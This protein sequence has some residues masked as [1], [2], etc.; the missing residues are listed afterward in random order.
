MNPTFMN[1]DADFNKEYY[2][3]GILPATMGCRTYVLSNCNG[4]PGVEG[5]GNNAPSTI[6]LP[7]I[8]ILANHN[9]DK[10]FEL[11]DKRID[12]TVEILM[13]RYE[14][15][16]KLKVKDLPFVCGHGLMRG[17][18]NLSLDDSIEPVMK[19]GT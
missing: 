8:G 16:K 1:I 11:L 13:H 9:I 14:I 12:D 6:N 19:N 18:E 7:R 2:D 10:F 15:L 3:K 17:S 5:R 4:K